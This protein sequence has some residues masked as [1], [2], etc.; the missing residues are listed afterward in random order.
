ME[1]VDVEELLD[2]LGLDLETLRKRWLDIRSHNSQ[3]GHYIDENRY[4]LEIDRLRSLAETGI[5]LALAQKQ[6]SAEDLL[7]KIPS[8][9]EITQK[10]KDSAP[11]IKDRINSQQWVN[12]FKNGAT[13][14]IKNLKHQWYNK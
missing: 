2:E 5:Q 9:L 11:E 12:G 6:A 8:S 14:I 3:I 10:A 7:K 1:K 4:R 13:W